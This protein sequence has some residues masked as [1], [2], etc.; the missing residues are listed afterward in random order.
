VRPTG[1][2]AGRGAAPARE[3]RPAAAPAPKDIFASDPAGPSDDGD[4]DFDVPSF[5]K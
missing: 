3:S 2:P 4:D 1:R 5:L